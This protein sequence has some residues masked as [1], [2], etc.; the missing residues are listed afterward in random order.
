MKKWLLATV[1]AASFGAQADEGMWQP[2]QLPAMADELKAKGLEIDAK[3]ISKLTEFPMNAVISLGGCTASFVSPKGLVVTNHHCAYGAIQYNST[4]E[5]NLL[6]DGFLAKT[7]ADELP[8]APG[9]RVY[10]TEDVTNVTERVN[11][12]LENKTGREFYQGVEEQEKTLVAECEKDEGYRCQV[13]SFHGGLEYYLVKQ[14][15]I[16]DVR[17]VYNPAASVGKYGGDVDNWMWPR[18]TGDFSF[19][20]A[21][22]SKAGKPADFSSDNVPYEPKSF[23]KVSAKGVSDGDFVMVA[24]Y[25][26][27]TNRYRTAN[28]V[29]N[30][31][32]W[33]Y[34]EGKLLR[35][36]FIEIIKDTAPEGSDERIKYESQIAS[37]ANY[38]KNF[39]SMIEFYGKSTMLADRKAREAELAAWIAKDSSREAKYGKTL[40]ELD[41]LIAKSKAHQERDMILSY[42][43]STTMLPTA[44]SLYRLANE[45]QLP[46]IQREP[47]F[48]ER[49][50]TRLKASMERIDRRYA[51]S[52]DKAV[53]FDMLKRYAAL[54]ED[55]RLPAL[56]KAFGIDKKF[57]EAKLSK[58]LDKMY[59][60]TELGKKDVR[61]AWMDKS[62]ADFKAS[63][64]PFI[65]FAVA[66]YDTDMAEEKKEKE[67]DGELMKV[68]PQYMDAIIAY[69]LEQGKPVY[70]DANSSLRVTVGHVKGYSPKDG[71]VAVPFTRLEGIVQKDTGVDPFDAPKKELE[72]IK[73]KQY[74]DFY[75]KAIDS[76]P[77]NFL[78]TLDTTGGNSGSPTLNGR[79]ELVG[80]LFDGVYESIIG[81]WAY[82]DNIN[83]SIQ[84]DSRYMLWVMK[85]LDHADN[86]L[87]EMEIV[88]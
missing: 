33:A 24:G 66:M 40:A 9:S 68:R 32:E 55:K 3:S 37:L 75:V 42:I 23:L 13:Y 49:D 83:R 77:V 2:H 74:G 56:D 19:Y 34:P 38:A 50:M 5:K 45:K 72:L 82:D 26:G 47:G 60:K 29:Q 39:T 20:R 25:P 86:L 69:N 73:Q 52:V 4:P 87:A 48:Q 41:A 36:R 64:D 53:L 16:R 12:G 84:V 1:V 59:A 17:L 21:Y 51:P 28:E 79:A 54:P 18:H 7:F 30:Q 31:F 10:V 15:E 81:D 44:R 63:K 6:Q 14:L 70:A 62:V 61:L 46:D 35:E 71:L 78:S 11:A 22:V 67:L 85:Y 8:A 43:G 80:L 88:K 58:T 27:R 57:S 65:Q 76:V